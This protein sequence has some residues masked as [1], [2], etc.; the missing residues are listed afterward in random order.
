MNAFAKDP[1]ITNNN[2]TD[3]APVLNRAEQAEQLLNSM[4]KRYEEEKDH[5]V[6]PDCISYSTVINAYANSNTP[7]SGVHADAILRRMTHRYLMGDT[8]CRPNAVAFTAAI[9]AHSAAINATLASLEPA[10]EDATI[11][12]TITQDKEQNMQSS[13][14]RCEDLLQQLCLLY[15]SPGGD[16]SLKP[17]S[18]TF[19]LTIRALTQV[20]DQDGVER[21]KQLQGTM[22]N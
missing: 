6:M 4:E 9:K 15:Q 14:K 18:V 13:A 1:L 12:D 3:N 20:Q 11:P 8:K 2:T 17:T 16:R 5:R 19:D 10:E 21:V 22:Q 7:H